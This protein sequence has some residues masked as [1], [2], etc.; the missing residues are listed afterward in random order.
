MQKGVQNRDGDKYDP[1]TSKRVKLSVARGGE[2]VQPKHTSLF[3]FHFISLCLQFDLRLRFFC[4]VWASMS[5]KHPA[6]MSIDCC[7]STACSVSLLLSVQRSILRRSQPEIDT[8][9]HFCDFLSIYLICVWVHVCVYRKTFT[10]F[11]LCT[12]RALQSGI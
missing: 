7:S 4:V 10:A 6:I 8:L 5:G 9:W 12:A 2:K 11:F 1:T 3:A